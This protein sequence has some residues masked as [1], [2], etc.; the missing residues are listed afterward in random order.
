MDHQLQVLL[1]IFVAVTALAVVTQLGILMALF[2]GVRRTQGKIEGILDRHVEPLL[3]TVR[4]MVS[5]SRKA[6]DRLNEAADEVAT[7]ARNQTGRLDQ[8]MAETT[9]RARL[10][11]IRA[12]LM[13][14]DALNRIEKTTES[15]QRGI[16]GPVREIQALLV[17]VR[18]ALDF[19]FGRR[20]HLVE[21]TTGDEELFI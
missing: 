11:L 14:A 12:D 5:N 1:V 16:A 15:V 8:L 6:V 20:R 13:V 3:V 2:L 4:D 19:L 10:Q 7:F 21:R 9:D 17:G 18:T